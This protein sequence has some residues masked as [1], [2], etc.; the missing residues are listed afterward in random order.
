MPS[1]SPRRPGPLPS[2]SRRRK[3][4]AEPPP[5]LFPA[6]EDLL[7]LLAVLAIASAAAA[8]CS[9]LHRRPEPFCDS[10][11]SPDDYADDS[12]QPCPQNGRCVDG[13]LECVQGFKRYGGSCIEDGLLSQTAAKIF[14]KHDVSDT[15][16]QLLSKN[17]AGLTEDGI[18]L[19]KARV[20]D[21][22]QGFFETSF[23]S[24]QA[25]AFKC[26]ELVAECHMPLTCQV[27][28]WIS[29]N[30]IFVASFSILHCSGDCAP[31]TRDK[32]YQ[33]ELRKYMNRCV[34]PL[35]IML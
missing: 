15:V 10:V 35:K 7:R 34:K 21:T 29:R 4:A 8:A 1:R 14:Q 27:R 31:F 3:G 13:Q 11:Q 9:G 26:P 28:H 32:H 18:Q 2:A 22:A 33:I 23:T 25:E 17:P 24:N 5:G 30:I 12:C 19:V 20:L 16:D 6:R